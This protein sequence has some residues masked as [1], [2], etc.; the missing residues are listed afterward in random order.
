M[1]STTNCGSGGGATSLKGLRIASLFIIWASSSF[2]ATFPTVAHR[3]RFIHL[4]VAVFESVSSPP[5]Q[6][7]VLTNS[8]QHGKIFWLWG[9]HRH[10]IH[11]P[12]RPRHQ[13]AYLALSWTRM[14]K[15]CPHSLLRS[16]RWQF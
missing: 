4:P 8:P 7:L 2:A 15:I 16:K 13:R 5:F 14:A 10:R 3:S 11:P 1:S 6:L 9:H 12:S